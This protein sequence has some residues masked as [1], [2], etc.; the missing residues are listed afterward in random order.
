[1]KKGILLF[2]LSALVAFTASANELYGFGLL[3]GSAQATQ[4]STILT[5]ETTEIGD[6]GAWGFSAEAY[7]GQRLGFYAGG[8]IGLISSYKSTLRIGQSETSATADLNDYSQRFFANGLLGI[9]YF[10]P[11]GGF[12][13]MVAAGFGL[14]YCLLQGEGS[15]TALTLA[16]L[17]PGMS[18]SCGIPV[19]TKVEA[20]L[21]L[22]LIYGLALL[23][24]YSDNYVSDYSLCP[25][26]GVRIKR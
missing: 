24:D 25:S 23:S 22:R 1:M 15:D 21:G 8:D 16:S 26:L 20:Y 12:D 9:G 17:G 19:S 5:I 3:Y 18:I 14:N 10:Q 2:C 7:I 4:S 11:L 6:Y 13:I